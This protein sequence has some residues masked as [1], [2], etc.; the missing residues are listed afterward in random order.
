MSGEL[1]RQVQYPLYRLIQHRFCNCT[2]Q[3]AIQLRDN[4][5]TVYI[6]ILHKI[7][8]AITTTA[9]ITPMIGFLSFSFIS[10]LQL[11]RNSPLRALEPG[12]LLVLNSIKTGRIRYKIASSKTQGYFYGTHKHDTLL[13]PQRGQVS[14]HQHKFSA[15]FFFS[16]LFSEF[17]FV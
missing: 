6:C 12:V 3:R 14:I 16:G 9:D 2:L 8:L 1:C 7:L 13:Q 4:V 10:F 11:T 5:F 17:M 15:F